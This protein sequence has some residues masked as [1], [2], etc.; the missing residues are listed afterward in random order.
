MMGLIV[1]FRSFANTPKKKE[2]GIREQDGSK[3]EGERNK[4]SY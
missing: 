2:L 3:E 1:T 4:K